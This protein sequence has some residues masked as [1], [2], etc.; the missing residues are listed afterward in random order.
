MSAELCNASKR[1]AD[2]RNMP[3]AKF[4]H[5]RLVLAFLCLITTGM[6]SVVCGAPVLEE[7]QQKVSRI[8]WVA[9]SPPSAN[10]VK[11]VSATPEALKADLLVLREAGFTGVV[12]YSASGVLG[13]ELPVLARSLGFEGVI[14]GVWDPRNANEIAAAK[15]C[16]GNP[17]VLGF[18]VGNEGLAK[19]YQMTD[20]SRAIQQ[21]REATGKPVTT[22]EEIDDY[23][24]ED[25]LRLGDWVFPNAHPYF[26][27]KLD[28]ASA[29]RW[30]QGA[31]EDLKRKCGRFVLFKEVGLPTEGDP[32]HRLSET[33]QEQYYL[34][35]A[36]TP[37][38]FVYFEAFDQPWKTHLPVEPH[39]GMFHSD[40][41]PKRLGWRLMGKEPTSRPA[42]QAAQAV[43]GAFYIYLDGD[44]P[45][46]HYKPTGYMGDC[47]DIHIDETF[48]DR[49]HSGQTCIRIVYDAKGKKP[50]ECLY[51]PPCKW[52]G[53][54][55]QHPP[56]NFG[57]NPANKGKGFDLSAYGRLVFWARADRK[58]KIEF[59]VGGID[60]PYG[61]SLSYPR[62]KT[63]KLNDKWREFQV[64]LKGADLKHIIGGFCWV[65][66]WD[67]N[68]DGV[69]FYLDDIRFDAGHEKNG[70][71]VSPEDVL[72]AN[73]L[74]ASP[75][76]AAPKKTEKRPALPS[77]PEGSQYLPMNTGNTW[78]YYKST[79]GKG[80][81]LLWALIERS[82]DKGKVAYITAKAGP[83]TSQETYTVQE[84]VQDG[85]LKFWQIRVDPTEARDGR[86]GSIPGTA[87]RVEKILW[88]RVPSSEH[89]IEIDEVI[90]RNPVFGGTEVREERPILPEPKTT[91]MEV[92][93][94]PGTWNGSSFHPT[95]VNMEIKA[96]LQKIDIVVPAGSWREVLEVTTDVKQEGAKWTTISYYVQGVG[97]VKEVQF[98]PEGSESYRL[99]LKSFQLKNP[100]HK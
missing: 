26:H 48:E 58:C 23:G 68:P 63:A 93:I 24:E 69:T 83:A 53:V 59:K 19:R 50:N 10:P 6:A 3:P 87:L 96:S 73:L 35:L 72:H 7:W 99:E 12:T 1:I 22:T 90:V 79:S 13:R 41:W 62:S 77:E 46:N 14:V 75:E 49:P 94:V 32:E 76:T 92:R 89:I 70:S 60:A 66:N 71:Q 38:R 52:A 98:D 82:G 36:E 88:G 2:R 78:T 17:I 55:W 54:Y 5:L 39:W 67:A 25:L 86:Y 56:N 33:A 42:R 4:S 45:K 47:G 30:T 61:D 11:G 43:A 8:R 16:S 9:Y 81:I 18:C 31:Y 27:N 15:A 28:P 40:R 80:E 74:D 34:K 65:S 51:R 64:D 100:D 37:V 84:S 97:L 57:K 44:S 29:V 91:D 85:R 21:L 95:P 20:L